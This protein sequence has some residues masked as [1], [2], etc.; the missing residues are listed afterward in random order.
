LVGASLAGLVL[1]LL[2]GFWVEYGGK[3]LRPYKVCAE[4]V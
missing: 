4:G 2:E 3:T 1:P